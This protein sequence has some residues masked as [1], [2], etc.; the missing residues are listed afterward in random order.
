MHPEC[1]KQLRAET[2]STFFLLFNKYEGSPG[3]LQLP[4]LKLLQTK[5]K[6]RG[7]EVNHS[8]SIKVCQLSITA[9]GRVHIIYWNKIGGGTP[10]QVNSMHQQWCLGSLK[11]LNTLKMSEVF[12][13]KKELWQVYVG[14]YD[15]LMCLQHLLSLFD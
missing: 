12:N 8:C 5:Q 13:A 9:G 10:L 11:D 3:A 1:A 14:H 15:A 2:H 4:K 7:L 6:Q